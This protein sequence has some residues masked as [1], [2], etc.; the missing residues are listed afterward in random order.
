MGKHT[1]I[2]LLGVAGLGLSL[3]MFFDTKTQHI[4]VAEE[5]PEEPEGITE[6]IDVINMTDEEEEEIRNEVKEEIRNEE[7]EKRKNQQPTYRQV[8]LE[9]KR[10]DEKPRI[11]ADHRYKGDGS[12]FDKRMYFM[13]EAYRRSREVVPVDQNIALAVKLSKELEKLEEEDDD[14]L[15]SDSDV[16]ET[17][18]S[19]EQVNQAVEA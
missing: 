12:R 9:K 8:Y 17:I 6:V 10:E 2:L 18:E 14:V 4:P 13:K 15:L 7:I 16:E 19:V 5:T 1:P 11:I 3:A